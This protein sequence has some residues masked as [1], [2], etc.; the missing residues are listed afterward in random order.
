MAYCATLAAALLCLGYGEP[1]RSA[2]FSLNPSADAF[3]TTGPT[4][5]LGANN[6]GGAGALCVAA[7]GLAQGEFQSVMQFSLAS[8]AASFNA[9]YGSGQWSIQSVTLQ[10]TGTPANNAIFN[11]AAAGQFAISLMQNNGW[12][13]GTGTP[14]APATNGITFSTLSNY[15]GAGDSSL[16]TFS[17]NGATNGTTSYTLNLNSALS[18][19]I[20]NGGTASLRL[21]A[22]DTAVSFLFDSRSF[23]TAADRPLL[24]ITAVPEPS[25]LALSALGVCFLSARRLRRRTRAGLA[26]PAN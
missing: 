2:T 4:G 24:I 13:E 3:A 19:E 16:G 8:A 6:Y 25:V 5:N 7:P 12:T 10:L 14:M 11:A 22:A 21:Y 26:G 17:F 9:Q 20:L 23:N 1:A 15:V 18:E